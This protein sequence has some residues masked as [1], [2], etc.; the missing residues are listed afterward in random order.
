[1]PGAGFC[2]DY[3]RTDSFA[4]LKLAGDETEGRDHKDK[5]CAAGALTRPF[6]IEAA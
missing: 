5:S 2:V 3:S 1:L 6:Y 4:R